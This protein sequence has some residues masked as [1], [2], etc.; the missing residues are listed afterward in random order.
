MTLWQP[1]N[2]VRFM[3]KLALRE[4]LNASRGGRAIKKA[5]TD[6]EESIAADHVLAALQRAGYMIVK[7]PARP[8]EPFKSGPG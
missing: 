7:D 8:G 4:G 5:M 2:D 1:S 6:S 3:V